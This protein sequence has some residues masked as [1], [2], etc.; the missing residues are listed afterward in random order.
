MRKVP[1]ISG[2]INKMY[3][4]SQGKWSIFRYVH[5]NLNEYFDFLYGD[6]TLHDWPS[7]F[8]M[9][10]VIICETLNYAMTGPSF[11]SF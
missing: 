9:A 7:L 11:E 1:S 2:Y 5:D 8:L 3:T 6:L 4:I 10:V